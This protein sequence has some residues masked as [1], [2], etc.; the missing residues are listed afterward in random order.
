VILNLD[1]A[2]FR[3][4]RFHPAAFILHDGQSRLQ[5]ESGWLAYLPDFFHRAGETFFSLRRFI[6]TVFVREFRCFNDRLTVFSF[7][8]LSNCSC[9]T[10][11]FRLVNF[12]GCVC[13][14]AA[15][16]KPNQNP[17]I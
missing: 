6:A 3:R 5:P 9:V 13:R 12:T 4:G 1:A 14:Y 11:G 15:L 7:F 16:M 17:L 2:I 8:S 10:A